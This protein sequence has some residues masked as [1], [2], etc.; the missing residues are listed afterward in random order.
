MNSNRAIG[1]SAMLSVG[2]LHTVRWSLVIGAVLCLSGIVCWREPEEERLLRRS[3]EAS[4]YLVNAAQ[5][6]QKHGTTARL[7][8]KAVEAYFSGSK[9]YEDASAEWRRAR[10]TRLAVM[11]MAWAGGGLLLAAGLRG[12]RLR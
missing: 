1:D 9:E 3:V 8:T 5:L 12:R 4:R 11:T 7:R 10:R 6:A 2:H